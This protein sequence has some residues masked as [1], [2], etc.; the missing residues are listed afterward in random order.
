MLRKVIPFRMVVNILSKFLILVS[1]LTV[2][3]ALFTPQYALG[4]HLRSVH[5]MD[6]YLCWGM[7]HGQDFRKQQTFYCWW[8]QNL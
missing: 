7:V 3:F 4:E 2:K 5:A 6:G 8:G 1:R